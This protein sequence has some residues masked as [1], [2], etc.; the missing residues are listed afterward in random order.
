MPKKTLATQPKRSQKA[1]LRKVWPDLLAYISEGRPIRAFLH[2]HS[3][4][5]KTLIRFVEQSP[6]SRQQYSHARRCCVEAYVA[7]IVPMSDAVIGEEMNVVTATR[8]AVDA[9][10]WVAGKLAPRE[11]GDVPTGVT[12]NNQTNVMVVSDDRLKQ[13]QALRQQM[14]NASPSVQSLPPSKA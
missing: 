8:N 6:E 13:L 2:Q 14:L 9:R 3:L 12:I 7:E 10:K 1:I 5:F 4:D 11:Y